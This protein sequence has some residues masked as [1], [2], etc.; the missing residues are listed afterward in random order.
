MFFRN[1]LN[2]VVI[3][4]DPKKEVDATLAFLYTIVQGHWLACACNILGVSSPDNPLTHPDGLLK[5][6]RPQQKLFVEQL[7][8]KIVDNLTLI[9]PAFLPGELSNTDDKVYNYSHVLCHYGALVMEFRDAWAEGDGE[10]VLCCWWLFMPHFQSSG[11]TKYALEAFRVQLQANVSLS[12]NLAHQVKWNRFVNTKGGIGK[13]IP[14]DL[15]NEH[16][17]KLIKYT[18]Q[19]M[20]ANLTEGSLQRAARSVSTLQAIS[21]KFDVQSAVSHATYAHSTRSDSQDL[22]RVV[23]VVT[24]CN[25][26]LQV[27]GRKHTCFPKM[28]FNPLQKWDREKAKTWID[29]K[30]REYLK[31]K[32][33]FRGEGNQ[34]DSDASD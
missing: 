28:H 30:K 31:Y 29:Q 14:C 18:V 8:S 6:S 4:K 7:A 9:G 27:A 10:R 16:V 24:Q 11:C 12:P 13:N 26:L 20:G 32:G 17:N 25:L 2:R 15:Y 22:M 33:C 23:A 5:A 21:K 19:N 34:S 3:G 1:C